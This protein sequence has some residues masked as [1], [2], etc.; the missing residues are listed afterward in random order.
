MTLQGWFEAF[1]REGHADTS[2]W[3][4]DGRC[5][6]VLP[7]AHTPS[8]VHG[9]PG[10]GT[11]D[12]GSERSGK[13]GTSSPHVPIPGGGRQLPLQSRSALGSALWCCPASP[14][15]PA[16]PSTTAASI[17]ASTRLRACAH[18]WRILLYAT[19]LVTIPPVRGAMGQR[20]SFI[21][22]TMEKLKKWTV[23]LFSVASKSP[24]HR[25]Q[26]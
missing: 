22:G 12:S 24:L 18:T 17:F 23:N 16:G 11:A 7:T 19:G 14:S 6:R 1:K 4:A 8:G 3:K 20:P 2:V 26:S 21:F 9:L 5:R 25:Q 13:G 10:A 15:V